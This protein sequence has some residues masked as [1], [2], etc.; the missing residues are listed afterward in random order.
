M[1]LGR[2]LVASDLNPDYLDFFPLVQRDWREVVGIEVSLVLIANDLPQSLRPFERAIR[3]FPPVPGLHTA[4]Q[5][6]CI[7]LLFPALL[8]SECSDAVVISDMDI[9][10]LRG[11]YFTKPL[12]QI[13]ADSFVEY[14][15]GTP[16]GQVWI[17]YN[18][19][20]PAT[21]GEV[22]PGV[23]GESDIAEILR[24]WWAGGRTYEGIRKGAGWYTDQIKLFSHLEAW[25]TARGRGRWVKL[26]DR[27]TGFGRLDRCSPE[28][29][30]QRLARYSHLL[31]AGYLTDFH[32]MQPH[33]EHAALNLRAYE[34]A[35]KPASRTD[36]ARA[37]LR[38]WAR[39]SRNKLFRR[40]HS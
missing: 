19:A 30:P 17:L 31:R 24:A 9:L 27:N 4:F 18:A 32:M 15:S 29:F 14:R 7:R 2:C 25:E 11:S 1:K 12:E 35:R 38:G 13:E 22:F 34:E 21:W 23:H 28:V 26:T 40:R 37:A 8:Q 3:V 33:S 6:Q 5:A 36:R 39:A 20:Q 10:P 16:L